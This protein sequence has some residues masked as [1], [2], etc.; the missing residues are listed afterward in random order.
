VVLFVLVFGRGSD[1]Q[2]PTIAWRGFL[3]GDGLTRCRVSLPLVLYFSAPLDNAVASPVVLWDATDQAPFTHWQGRYVGNKS[4]Y[5]I[6]FA[7]PLAFG[8][9][10][11]LRLRRD[12]KGFRG[13]AGQPV[14]LAAI[15]YVHKN[16]GKHEP[17]PRWEDLYEVVRLW[18]RPIHLSNNSNRAPPHPTVADF[19][20][21]Y[22]KVGL[23]I[24][25]AIACHGGSAVVLAQG[26][27]PLEKRRVRIDSQGR[28]K[29]YDWCVNWQVQQDSK[30]TVDDT[31]PLFPNNVTPYFVR[32]AHARGKRLWHYGR[33]DAATVTY[34]ARLGID[35]LNAANRLAH[36]T[37]LTDPGRTKDLNA[38]EVLFT[39]HRYEG[40]RRPRIVRL[41]CAN[42]AL[43]G[44]ADIPIEPRFELVFDEPIETRSV[45]YDSLDLRA[46]GGGEKIALHIKAGGDMT[47]L[48]LRAQTPLQPAT[49]YVLRI[50]KGF[51]PCDL[52][53]LSLAEPTH[54]RFR[55]AQRRD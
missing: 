7:K 51:E 52:A 25:K 27:S 1:A 31:A 22:E 45:N 16:N 15:D 13:A 5:K 24:S 3:P 37:R 42:A 33:E 39:L 6:S 53:G 12:G 26:K 48:E 28:V 20:T 23:D 21:L 17:I 41:T 30:S 4:V 9:R 40:D 49:S 19:R 54:C 18:D 36:Q 32:A 43:D 11:E 10:Y 55:T 2:E 50:G 8:H 44:R 38:R 35:V 14:E 46:A 34:A 29:D 47:R